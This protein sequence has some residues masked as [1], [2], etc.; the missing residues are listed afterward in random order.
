MQSDALQDAAE[1]LD[2][3]ADQNPVIEAA[4]PVAEAI[5]GAIPDSG[6][7]WLDSMVDTLAQAIGGLIDGFV[8]HLPQ[9]VIALILLTFTALV[10]SVLSKW[11]RRLTRKLKLAENLRDLVE[12]LS[13]VVVWFAGL[14]AAA[15]VVFPGLGA[16]ELV[17]S[18]GLASIAIGFAFQD[19]FE[20]FLAGVLI[21]W[22]FPFNNGDWIAIPAEDV[23]GKVEEV[24]IRMSLIRSVTDELLLIPNAMIYKNVVRVQTDQNTRRLT[25]MCGIAYGE[26]VGEGR[27]VI[28]EA[29]EGCETVDTD[30]P[31]QVFAHGF[32]ASS[33]DFEVTWWA[34]STPLGQRE[35]RDEVIEA[36]KRGLDEAGIE[37]PFPHRTLTFSDNEPKIIEVFRGGG[38][39]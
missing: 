26:D 32:G 6:V 12:K 36:V 21:I 27:R 25:V 33:I 20:N 3:G 2:E 24:Q 13:R 11:S 17:A 34:K 9:L 19:I 18:A 10:A 1:A 14:V 37:I 28:R 8:T 35:S 5:E 15:G 38:G 31:V 29:L 23:E 39:D 16:G 22:R 4:G 30:K 7:S